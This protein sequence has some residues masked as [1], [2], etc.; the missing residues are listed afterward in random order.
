MRVEK[1]QRKHR[2]ITLRCHNGC[3]ANADGRITEMGYRVATHRMWLL[4]HATPLCDECKVEWE[5]AY[6]GALSREPEAVAA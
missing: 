5:R 2:S 1:I 6:N 3:K 4:G